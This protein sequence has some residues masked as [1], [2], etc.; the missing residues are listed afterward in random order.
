MSHLKDYSLTMLNTS[1]LYPISR[2]PRNDNRFTK[3]CYVLAFFR[4]SNSLNKPNSKA[5]QVT[6]NNSNRVHCILTI[7]TECVR[8]IYL[9]TLQRVCF[10]RLIDWLTALDRL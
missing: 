10:N 2:I 9:G 4:C 7:H 5:H 3:I 6:M 1:L 8:C